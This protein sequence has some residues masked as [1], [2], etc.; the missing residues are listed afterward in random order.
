MYRRRANHYFFSWLYRSLANTHLFALFVSFAFFMA[1]V[2]ITSS[3]RRPARQNWHYSPARCLCGLCFA[4]LDSDYPSIRF[5][6]FYAIS[7]RFSDSRMN[8]ALSILTQAFFPVSSIETPNWWNTSFLV[9]H[10]P[11]SYHLIPILFLRYLF[12]F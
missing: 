5:G 8:N 12:S 2:V 1:L 11:A 9:T 7:T 4:C 3:T 6:C 10:T